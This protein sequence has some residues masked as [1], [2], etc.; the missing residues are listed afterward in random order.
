MTGDANDSFE[1]LAFFVEGHPVPQGSK[2]IVGVGGRPRLIDTNA[3]H[4]KPWRAKVTAVAV[5]ALAGRDPIPRDVPVR[6]VLEFLM[7]RPK[8]VR[9][10]WPTVPPDIDKTIRAILDALTDAGV[11]GDDSQV[12]SLSA[13]K[14]YA[15]DM[16][17]V[18]VRVERK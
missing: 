6:V 2:R 16:P 12:V 5:E 13:V 18:N 9:R 10:V 17:G 4:L 8:S 11:W 14:R 3:N 15:D 7:P 1:S